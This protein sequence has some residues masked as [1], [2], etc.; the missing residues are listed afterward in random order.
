MAAP[1]DREARLEEVRR[2]VRDFPDAP[3]IYLFKNAYDSVLYV[4]K[5]VSLKKRVASYFNK[6]G[7]ESPKVRS[8][9]AQVDHLDYVLTND[10]NQAFLLEST[11]IKR[12]RPRYNVVMRD[13]KS[14]PYLKLTAR[15]AF[16]RVLIS[17]RPVAD[18]SKY[19][20]PFPNL[21]LREILK[22]IYRY[23]NI[24][25]CDIDIDG[26]A[27]RA[28]LSYQI[29]QCPAPCIGAVDQAGYAAVVERVKW[30]LEGKHE[31]L[32]VHL[33]AEMERA[34]ERLEY[35]EA[36]KVRDL[37]ASI[38][39]MQNGYA[40]IT[41]EKLDL[42]VVA[43][44]PGLGKVLASVL[45]VRQGKVVDHVKLVLENELDQELPEVLPFFLRQFYSPGVFVPDEILLSKE[46]PL[47]PEV[48]LWAS[49]LKDKKVTVKNASGGWRADLVEIAE[50]NVLSA[51]KEDLQQ[52][53][54]LKDLQ[55]LLGLKAV[56]RNIACF[57][58]S[59]LQGTFTVGS[60]VFFRDGVPDKGR[61]R[62]FKIKEIEGQDDF[63]SHQEMMRRYIALVEREGNPVPDLLLIDGGKGQL[64]AVK[65]VL[66]EV[67][68][69]DYGLASLAKR[70]EEVF[71]PGQSDP[72]DFKGH[73]KA[74][75]LLQR[76][77]DEAHRFAVGYHR[78]IRDRSAV[79]SLLQGVKG[80]GPSRLRALLNNFESVEQVKRAS[81]ED[82][83]AVPHFSKE[84]ANK[85]YQ[86]FHTLT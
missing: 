3:G 74:R 24:R 33:R 7:Q 9:V 29:K 53:E 34:A 12:H 62:K 72:V 5:A 10:E 8:L 68:A 18:G 36:A 52:T 67:L 35:E 61:Y 23:F 73:L 81:L 22:M 86:H 75:Y 58:I 65:A 16:P 60:A 57:D 41:S 51:L 21:K 80:I 4:G 78:I 38:E 46:M 71:L 84:L 79:T 43:L 83:E 45:Q 37:L 42:D 15:E 27:E 28:C 25:D 77:R 44:T 50:R 1:A 64:S 82:L 19:Y 63:K 49:G 6:T 14:Y 13:D 54:V 66:D 11:L 69:G 85:L 39:Q 31:S 70:E 2:K 40:V 32:M 26:K 20:G 47:D 30:F 56:P 76:V 59:T 48:G 55:K 17:R